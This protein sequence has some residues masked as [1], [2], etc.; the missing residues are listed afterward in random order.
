MLACG[1]GLR[2]PAPMKAVSLDH[3]GSKVDKVSAKERTGFVQSGQGFCQ[4]FHEGTMYKTG[5]QERVVVILIRH[6]SIVNK[7]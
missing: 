6:I 2:F 1:L 3:E 5:N 4:G 7:I